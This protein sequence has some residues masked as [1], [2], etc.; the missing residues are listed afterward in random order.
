M[1]R[2]KKIS[3][4][5]LFLLLTAIIPPLS[6]EVSPYGN[7]TVIFTLDVCS[8]SHGALTVNTEVPAI[9]EKNAGE[10]LLPIMGH[11]PIAKSAFKTSV[12]IIKKDRPPEI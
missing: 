8:A 4:L 3:V 5:L 10:D 12:F 11:V 1:L 7:E 9:Q 2:M 6:I